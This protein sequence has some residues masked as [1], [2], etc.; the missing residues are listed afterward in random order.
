M[1]KRGTAAI[2]FASKSSMPSALHSLTVISRDGYLQASP[3]R[4]KKNS[5]RGR[6]SPKIIGPGR[7]SLQQNWPGRPSIKINWAGLARPN[8]NSDR[9]G[10]ARPWKDRAGLARP[11]PGRPK[12]I[13][14]LPRYM[15][16]IFYIFNFIIIYF[17]LKL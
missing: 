10:S 8:K 17:K 16:I 11:A 13:Y 7:P 14:F 3:A 12:S 2:S 9:A 15:N 1:E 6:P 4:P 5:G